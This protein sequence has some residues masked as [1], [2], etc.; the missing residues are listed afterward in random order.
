M[1]YHASGEERFT[2][3]E[4]PPD[5]SQSGRRAPV[6]ERNKGWYWLFLLPFFG[7]FLPWIYNTNDPELIGIPF[8]YWYQMLWVP[9]TVVLTVFVYIQ[10]RGDRS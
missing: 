6:N 2:H 5:R 8:F 7:V 9:L 1:A 10:T 3:E 4:R